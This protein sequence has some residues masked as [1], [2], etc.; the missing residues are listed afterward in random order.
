[1]KYLAIV[2]GVVFA[3]YLG[4]FLWSMQPADSR[5]GNVAFVDEKTVPFNHQL[6][7]DSIGLDCVSCHTGSRSGTSALLPTKK[8]CQD[9]H[10]FPLTESDGIE[11]LNMALNKAPDIPWKKMR[12]L[13]EHVFFHHG[14]HSAAGVRCSDCHGGVNQN[15]YGGERLDMKNCLQCHR[16]ETFTERGFKA[17]TYCAA[18]HR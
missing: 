7:G 9:C 2:L 17:A 6:H 4:D 8:D 12:L 14:V 11:K 18:C 16:G 10:R 3:F 15:V 5:V 13:P 1:M